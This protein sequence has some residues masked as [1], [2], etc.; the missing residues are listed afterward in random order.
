MAADP[1]VS[2]PGALDFELPAELS[3]REPAEARGL[4][5]DGVRLLLG[6]RARPAPNRGEV[7][8]HRFTDLP[9]LLEA[10][11]VLVVNTSE[12]FPAA[13][14]VVDRPGLVVHASTERPDGAKPFQTWV[15]ELRRRV[16]GGAT[17][18]F[19]QGVAG[20]ELTVAGGAVVRLLRPYTRDRLWVA[21]WSVG[22]VPA[23]L[24]A[25]GR[26][27]RYSYVDRDWPIDTYKTV[28]A[29]TPGSAEMPSASR[30]FTDAVV[31]RLATRGILFAPILLHTGVASAEAHE[32]PYPERY[33][34]PATTARLVNEARA[35]GRRIIAVGTTAV[36]AV[37]TVADERGRLRAASGWTSL[38]V[39]PDR[40][41]RAVDGLVTGFHEPR[42]SHLSM[43][44]A[45]AGPDL[46]ADV[47]T[48]ALRER[49]LWHE[50]GD[51]NLLLSR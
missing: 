34:V 32:R 31:R 1:T 37:E 42:A 44:T 26:P 29:T 19:A 40:G 39:T 8:H 25:H 11:D 12:T 24:A 14:D 3:A 43:L 36:R 27:I 22:D 17:Q 50:F 47:Y 18:P 41:V 48:E 33:E 7:S 21:R 49:Y 23:Y 46:L 5:R 16:E 2:A 30:P 38:V 6:R 4:A 35:A 13:V 45:I 51:I 9:D 15:V 20:D 10:G 28:F